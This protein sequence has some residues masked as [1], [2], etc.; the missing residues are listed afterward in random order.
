MTLIRRINLAINGVSPHLAPYII[1]F[2]GTFFLVLTVGLGVTQSGDI[3]AAFSIGT[4][5]MTMIF[6]GG[7][8]SG[9]FKSND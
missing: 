9:F 6:M 1:E 8:I 7:H 5:L 3:F 4:I 2:I